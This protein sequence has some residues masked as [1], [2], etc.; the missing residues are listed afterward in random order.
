MNDTA[1]KL[2]VLTVKF[3]PSHGNRAAMHE[4]RTVLWMTVK[5]KANN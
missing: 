5:T 1:N 3:E 4:Q 2:F